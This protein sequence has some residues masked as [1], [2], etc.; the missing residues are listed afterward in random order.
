[1]Q[2]QDETSH[3]SVYCPH[4]DSDLKL[5]IVLGTVSANRERAIR[6]GRR[7]GTAALARASSSRLSTV[8][9]R[10]GVIGSN[11]RLRHCTHYVRHLQEFPGRAAPLRGWRPDAMGGSR[12][13]GCAAY[14]SAQ[15]QASHAE[16]T[17]RLGNEKDAY[18]SPN[19]R[20]HAERIFLVVVPSDTE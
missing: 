17:P 4:M 12:A 1:M 16:P 8:R 18:W 6:R 20:S 13:A 11:H 14:A 15:L 10:G 5:N 19:L 9:P 7:G 2:F 3:H